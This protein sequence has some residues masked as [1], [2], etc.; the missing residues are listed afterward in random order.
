MI[1]YFCVL[2]FEAN[3]QEDGKP[4][5]NEIIE[6]P[7]ILYKLTDENKLIELGKFESF[8][9]PTFYPI[10]TP[11][12]T[13]LTTITQ[14]DVDNADI[15]PNVFN[16]VKRWLHEM[17]EMENVFFNINN[18]IIVTCGNWDIMTMLPKDLEKW[19]LRN[20][21]KIWKRWFNI[22]YGYDAVYNVKKRMSMP[23]MLNNINLELI[24]THHRG[25]D[26]C[27]NIGNILVKM[28]EDGFVF[29]EK[30]IKS[31]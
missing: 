27:I 21:K 16:N 19:G 10:L 2:D 29:D 31:A 11:F 5:I 14:Q 13:N 30:Y 17:S 25:I 26:D 3:C 1:K 6:F 12:C 9:K 7:C 8:V 20:E 4:N 23:D 22:K 18:F 24:G 15:F 28:F